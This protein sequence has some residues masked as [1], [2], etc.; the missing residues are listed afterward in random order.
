[1]CR[2]DRYPDPDLAALNALASIAAAIDAMIDRH[3]VSARRRE[4]LLLPY[5]PPQVRVRNT[6]PHPSSAGRSFLANA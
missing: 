2:A 3:I 1:V 4:C 5:L 6:C